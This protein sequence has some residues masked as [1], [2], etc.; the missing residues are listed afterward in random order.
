M[1][2]YIPILF[3]APM[4][5]ALL[6]GTKTQ[7]RRIVKPKYSNTSLELRTDK[8]GTR[9]V[10]IQNDVPPPVEKEDGFTTRH[11]RLYDEVLPKCKKGDILWVR[12]S[13]CLTQPKDPE[14]YHFGYKDGSHSINAASEKYNYHS[15]NIWKPSIHMPKEACRIFLEVVN[16][17]AEKLRDIL[18]YDARA[19]GI[20]FIEG[21]THKLY[22]NYLTLDYGCTELFSFMTLWEKIN[23]SKSW[24]ENPFVWVYEFK[25]IDKPKDF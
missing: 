15:P 18:H 21:L 13:F 8:Y 3:S 20:D 17:K 22:Y 2:R 24:E 5:K 25:I 7:T 16:V 10:E 23:G 4:V 14:T 1:K 19:E 11:I 9:L 12:E 6:K